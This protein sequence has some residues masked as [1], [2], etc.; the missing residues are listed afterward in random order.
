MRKRLAVVVAVAL[1]AVGL[2]AQPALDQAFAAFWAAAN[3]GEASARAEG[4]VA[5]NIAFADA[6]ARLREGRTYRADAGRGIVRLSHR[7]GTRE[8]PYT[9][10]VPQSY[11]PARRYQVRVQ[12]HGGVGRPDATPR[13]TG[14]IGALAG[15]QQIY[16]LP[17]AWAEAPWWSERQIENLRAILDTVK[18]TYNVDENRVALAGVSDGGTAAYYVAMRDTT[19]FSSFLPLNGFILVLANPSMGLGEG[20]FPNNLRNKPFFVVNGGQDPLYPAA[21]VE[22]FVRHFQQGGV[23]T[24]YLPQPDAVHNT[25]WWPEVK[26]AFETFVRTHPRRPLP[27]H[28]TWETDGTG[29]SARAHWLVIDRLAASADAALPDL[30]D[31]VA[32]SE[33]NFGVRASGMHVTSVMKGSNAERIGLLPG[34]VVLGVNGRNIP[35]GVPLVDLLSV[36]DPKTPMTFRLARE[37]KP[38]ELSGVFEPEMMPHVVPIFANARPSGRVDLARDGNTVRATTSG[39]AAFT[40][41]LSPDMFDFARAITVVAN[42]RTVFNGRVTPSVR[43]LLKW[44]ARDNDRTMLFGAELPIALP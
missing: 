17:T 43:T 44:A 7:L 8:Y 1:A 16:V 42:G 39:V 29:V 2:D 10:D 19:P 23:E 33:L 18:R 12:L 24:E 20:L 6:F 4:V 26:G 21:R 28:L 40:L 31:R 11:D 25:A 13:G 35:S 38:V 32:G 15:D 37:G 22:P 3:A 30:N 41:L 5:T 34:D 27:D 9:L 14:G 36:Y